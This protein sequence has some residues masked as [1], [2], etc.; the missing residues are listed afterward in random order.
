MEKIVEYLKEK[1]RLSSLVVS[2]DYAEDAVR[3]S[4]T[5]EAVG[6]GPT[7]PYAHETGVVEGVKLDVL[8]YPR[9]IFYGEIALDDF[10]Q[11]HEGL[12][13]LDEDGMGSWLKRMIA[14]QIASIPMKPD[15]AVEDSLHWCRSM[16]E[17]A[18][19]HDAEGYFCRHWLLT[20]SVE[21]YCDVCGIPFLSPRKTMSKMAKKDPEAAKIHMA[22][23][24]DMSDEA[25]AAWV[26]LLESCFEKRK[27]GE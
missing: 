25:L 6:L 10:E 4:S 18:L 5:F 23:L 7:S 24:S 13:A 1:Y 14:N 11:L 19:E 17:R 27:K 16:A 8:V 26:E 21:V 15:E 20:D 9:E 22:A 12:V 3:D 2:G